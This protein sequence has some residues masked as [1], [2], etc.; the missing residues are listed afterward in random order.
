MVL[1]AISD[2]SIQRA[3]L[4][5][6]LAFNEALADSEVRNGLAFEGN[7]TPMVYTNLDGQAIDV[8]EAFCRMIGR[9][10]EEVLGRDSVPFTYP[11]DVGITEQSHQRLATSDVASVRYVKR[12]VHRDGRVIVVEASKSPARSGTN[13]PMY[14]LTTSATSP[15]ASGVTRHSACSPK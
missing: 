9:T 10:R 15:T 5:A 3:A 6:M 12:Y 8:N 2:D 7:L 13:S 14:F 1:I 4:H 11:D